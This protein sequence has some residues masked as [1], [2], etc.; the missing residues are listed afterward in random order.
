MAAVGEAVQDRD[1]GGVGDL[2]QI[3]MEND[4]GNN[5]VNVG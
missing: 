4:T 1:A 5:A 3:L 2:E